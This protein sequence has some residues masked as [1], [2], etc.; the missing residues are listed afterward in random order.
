MEAKCIIY[1]D[2]KRKIP[3]KINCKQLNVFIVGFPF[4]IRFPPQLPLIRR[5]HKRDT[6]MILNLISL[7]SNG[8]FNRK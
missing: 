8:L 5:V 4:V 3:E 1:K 7:F 6:P 2:P